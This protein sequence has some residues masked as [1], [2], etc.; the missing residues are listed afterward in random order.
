MAYTRG[1]H[2]TRVRRKQRESQPD[3]ST[4]E[5]PERVVIW[6]QT[7]RSTNVT[8]RPDRPS[9]LKIELHKRRLECPQYSGRHIVPRYRQREVV[10]ESAIADV[11]SAEHQ[12]TADVREYVQHICQKAT[13]LFAV[14]AYME[15][16]QEIRTFLDEGITDERLPLRRKTEDFQSEVL[17]SQWILEAPPKNGWPKS[18]VKTIDKWDPDDREYFSNAQKLMTSPVFE[19]GERYSFDDD[20]I[21]PFLYP[22][23]W[24]K[25]NKKRGG[26]YSEIMR[27]RP[28]ESHHNFWDSSSDRN[29]ERLVVVKRLI[30]ADEKEIE[31]EIEN[32]QKVG[33]KHDHLIQLFACYEY[34]RSMHLILPEAEGDLRDYW[35]KR[36]MPEFN[37]ETIVWSLK[38]MYGIADGLLRV[39]EFTP[40]W[41]CQ[42]EGGIQTPEPDVILRTRSDEKAY[43][44][45]GDFKPE[46]ILYFPSD[47]EIKDENGILKITDYGLSRFHGRESRSKSN[48]YNIGFSQTYEPPEIRL[49]IP[50]SRAYDFW[51]LGCVY[52]EFVTWLTKGNK[53]IEDFSYK[54]MEAHNSIPHLMEDI[55]F[56]VSKAGD[57]IEA[58]VRRGVNDWIESL[59]ECGRCSEL[60]H[61]LL[62][63]ISGR[64][65][66]VD[67][68]DRIKAKELRDTLKHFSEKAEEDEY[69]LVPKPSPPSHTQNSKT[70]SAVRVHFAEQDGSNSSS[71]R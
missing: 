45:H 18:H 65:L 8:D 1:N 5:T 20:V 16:P 3:M 52:L 26:G 32:L 66:C 13:Q 50:V 15:R 12:A 60:I 36:P 2:E 41:H 22:K 4:R 55:F 64:M 53:A 43:G 58:H 49:G 39:H 57:E 69:L 19:R 31:N 7:L 62:D 10:T 48:P 30:T 68:Q 51:S 9:P 14:L 42:Q 34:Q 47:P 23:S 17:A 44:R 21:L 35:E 24:E 6:L 40:S 29:E 27:W 25:N 59:H 71:S 67:P 11:I 46:N 56:T 70:L 37:K 33:G 63:L 38:Q 54:R 28:I 61:D